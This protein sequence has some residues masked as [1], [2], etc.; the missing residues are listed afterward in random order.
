M[1]KLISTSDVIEFL[2]KIG[3]DFDKKSIRPV[4]LPRSKEPFWQF[5]GI[6]R[7]YIIT[8]RGDLVSAL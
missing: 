5:R 7:N 4:K 8:E 2:N 3:I 6:F 1:K